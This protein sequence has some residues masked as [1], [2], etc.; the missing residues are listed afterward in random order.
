MANYCPLLFLDAGGRNITPDR[1]PAEDGVT[2][3]WDRAVAGQTYEITAAGQ[4]DE[5]NQVIS[6]AVTVTA[7]ESDIVLTINTKLNLKEPSDQPS[8]VC[9]N[10]DGTNH[11][12]AKLSY[13]PIPNAKQYYATVG[14]S[15]GANDTE[16]K[17]LSAK[18]NVAAEMT[19]YL[20][21]ETGY[22]TRYAY[23]YCTDCDQEDQQNWSGYS[24]T[25]GFRCP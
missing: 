18:A 4:V 9:G 16:A 24:P 21:K 25:L 2:F 23:T 11:F 13:P 20:A 8:V 14:T 3:S 15:A 1:L 22:F 7:P 19:V 17:L 12:N 10:P 5:T 6:N